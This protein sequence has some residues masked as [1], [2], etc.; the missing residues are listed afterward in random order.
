M[1]DTPQPREITGRAQTRGEF[2]AQVANLTAITVWAL[3]VENIFIALT[4]TVFLMVFMSL[5]GIPIPQR[6]VDW[7]RMPTFIAFMLS[8]FGGM[9]IMI[10]A[11]LEPNI[12][13]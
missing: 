1:N 12:L 13:F 11:G 10:L 3:L 4:G 7:F 6:V 9:L 8:L 2:I 5:A